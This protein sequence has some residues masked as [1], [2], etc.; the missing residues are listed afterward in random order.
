MSINKRIK[1]KSLLENIGLKKKKN[2]KPPKDYNDEETARGI[3][4]SKGQSSGRAGRAGSSGNMPS[5]V[6]T[7]RS[8][9]ELTMDEVSAIGEV[10][11]LLT[12]MSFVLPNNSIYTNQKALITTLKMICRVKIKYINLT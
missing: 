12:P 7:A 8:T 5:R 10:D 9:I 1:L 11:D 4:R 3:T 2:E 6:N